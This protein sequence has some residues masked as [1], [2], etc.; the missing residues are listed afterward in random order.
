MANLSKVNKHY[1]SDI[2]TFLKEQRKS[3]PLTP[4]QAAEIAK[5]KALN[6]RRDYVQ[7]K[8]DNPLLWEDFW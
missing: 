7:E 5:Y 1:V 3:C 4:A 2:D 8:D 6:N